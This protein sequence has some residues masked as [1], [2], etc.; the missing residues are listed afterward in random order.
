MTNPR[1]TSVMMPVEPSTAVIKA[2]C[3]AASTGIAYAPS[4]EAVMSKVYRAIIAAHMQE[5]DQ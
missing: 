5:Q 3:N 4:L 2:M 1:E